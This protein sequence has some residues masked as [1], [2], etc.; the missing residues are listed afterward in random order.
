MTEQVY[1]NYN[2]FHLTR[3][4]LNMYMNRELNNF[5]NIKETYYMQK[6]VQDTTEYVSDEFL[7]NIMEKLQKNMVMMKNST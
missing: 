7:E 1:F 2:P 5:G 4:M 3:L 6:A